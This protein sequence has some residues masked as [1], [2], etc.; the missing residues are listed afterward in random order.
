MTDGNHLPPAFRRALAQATMPV[1][2][3]RA[4]TSADAYAA[5]DVV[6]FPS[7]WEGFGNPVLESIAHRKPI[8]PTSHDVVARP[9]V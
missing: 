7:T 3:G 2:V 5:G 6:L 4:A 9:P 8:G 1:T